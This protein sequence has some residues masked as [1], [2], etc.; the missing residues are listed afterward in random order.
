MNIGGDIYSMLCASSD[1]K[2]MFVEKE[3]ENK[4]KKE[5]DEKRDYGMLGKNEGMKEMNTKKR[6]QIGIEEGRY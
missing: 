6:M 1:E 4:R 2:G 3:R 5:R